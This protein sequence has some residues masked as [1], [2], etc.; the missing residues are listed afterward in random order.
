MPHLPS[1][2]M[3]PQTVSQLQPWM[4]VL[5]ITCARI[6]CRFWRLT[7]KASCQDQAGHERGSSSAFSWC[8]WVFH[9]TPLAAIPKYCNFWQ[10][11]CSSFLHP[12]IFNIILDLAGAAFSGSGSGIMDRNV[13]ESFKRARSTNRNGHGRH[14]V[15]NA[16][17]AW[18]LI[19]YNSLEEK[20][21]LM[22]S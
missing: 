9:W 22:G 4:G 20:F 11:F 21:A 14:R 15:Q 17:S 5:N 1:P 13:P 10:N 6:F 2:K 12:V 7:A 18:A 16:L 3:L 19:N 8:C